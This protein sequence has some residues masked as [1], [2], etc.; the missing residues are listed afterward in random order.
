MILRAIAIGA[1][2]SALGQLGDHGAYRKQSCKTPELASSC[3]H[4]HARLNAGNGTPAVRLWGVGTHHIY[5]IYSNT[6]GFEHDVL[7]LDN[8]A[9]E[10]P[11]TVLR[12][13]PATGGWTVYGD[14]EVCPLE[15]HVEGHMQA[16]CIAGAAHV[17]KD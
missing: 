16:A 3:F 6:Y 8:E 17:V 12:L 13:L 11:R 7:T 14:F 4:I 9:P 1:L 2:L 10:L 5:G 15:P